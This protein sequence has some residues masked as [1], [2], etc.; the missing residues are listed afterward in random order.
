MIETLVLT[1]MLWAHR[2]VELGVGKDHVRSTWAHP[3]HD[4]LLVLL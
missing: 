3:G 2:E 4:L 1:C